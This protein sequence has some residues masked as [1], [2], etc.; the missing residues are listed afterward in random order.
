MLTEERHRYIQALLTRQSVVKSQALMAALDASESTIRRDLADMESAGQLRRIHGGAERI[1]ASLVEL[2][3]QEK[4]TQA[5]LEKQQ[6]AQAAVK[7]LKPHQ[8]IFLDAGTSTAQMIPLLADREVTV[9]TTGVDNASQLADYGI[10]TRLL[11]GSVKPTTKALIGAITVQQMEACRF[12]FAFIGANGV[13]L[14]YGLTTPDQEEAAV[15]AAAIRQAKTAVIL[16]DPTKFGQVSFARF[17]PI[18]AGIILT[19]ALGDIATYYEDQT[20]IKEVHA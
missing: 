12:D 18:S 13:H 17:A 20:N 9:V 14:K 10:A 4:A 15:K 5:L 1:D 11:G 6:I 7:L 16:A 2:S 19:T 8:T 3:V